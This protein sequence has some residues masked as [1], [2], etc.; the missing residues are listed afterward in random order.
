MQSSIQS[1]FQKILTNMTFTLSA[2]SSSQLF[3]LHILLFFTFFSHR[4]LSQSKHTLRDTCITV[5]S[6]TAIITVLSRLLEWHTDVNKQMH[7]NATPMRSCH[8]SWERVN[9]SIIKNKINNQLVA[10]VLCW[11]CT[12]FT[13]SKTSSYVWPEAICLAICFCVVVAPTPPLSMAVNN[14]LINQPAVCPRL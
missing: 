1:V 6:S 2:T 4:H 14:R 9:N 7:L 13:E 11:T 12:S 8:C 10:A 5:T 3:L